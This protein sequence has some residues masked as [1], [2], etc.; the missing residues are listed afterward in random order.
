MIGSRGANARVVVAMATESATAEKVVSWFTRQLS[1]RLL[2]L[3]MAIGIQP[4]RPH[5]WSLAFQKTQ[6]GSTGQR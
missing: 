6:R 4:L 1:V 3:A 2:G 5:S